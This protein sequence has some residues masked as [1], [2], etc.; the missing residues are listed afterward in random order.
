MGQALTNKGDRKGISRQAIARWIQINCNKEGGAQF[1]TCLRKAIEKGMKE[2]LLKAGSTDARYKIG[3]LPKPKKVVKKT[4]SKK[5]I[6]PK[7]RQ[8]RRRRLPPRRQIQRRNLPQRRRPLRRRK[9]ES[10][11]DNANQKKKSASKKKTASKKKG[12]K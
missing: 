3:E 2:G 10:K 12:G 8:V 7:R 5:K 6:L 11:F 1:N 4:N 9:V